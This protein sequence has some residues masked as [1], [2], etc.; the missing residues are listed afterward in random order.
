MSFS[1][2]TAA[3]IAIGAAAGAGLTL[4]LAGWIWLRVRRLREGQ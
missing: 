1:A 4:L 2:A 3:W